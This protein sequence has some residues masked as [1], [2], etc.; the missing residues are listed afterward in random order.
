MLQQ[1]EKEKRVEE[2]KSSLLTDTHRKEQERVELQKELNTYLEEG[3][4]SIEEV[5]ELLSSFDG[6]DPFTSVTGNLDSQLASVDRAAQAYG[7]L[8]QEGEQPF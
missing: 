4:L 8:I 3:L 2:L 5:Q 1:K 6:V 7:F